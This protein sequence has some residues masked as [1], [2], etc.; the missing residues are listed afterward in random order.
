MPAKIPLSTMQC[1]VLFGCL[2][3]IT[4]SLKMFRGILQ[5][6]CARGDGIA[7][8]RENRVHFAER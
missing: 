6:E 2:L 5:G 4:A 1:A 3:Q 8:Q 7:K